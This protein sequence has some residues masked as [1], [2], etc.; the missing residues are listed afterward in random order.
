MDDERFF[1]S[2]MMETGCFELFTNADP[3]LVEKILDS[4]SNTDD[5]TLEEIL[6]L[7]G[8]YVHVICLN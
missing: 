8:Y 5:Q 2:V 1:Q 4:D 3:E 6:E 7:H